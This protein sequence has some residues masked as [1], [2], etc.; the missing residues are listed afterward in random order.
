VPIKFML[1]RFEFAVIVIVPGATPEL[2]IE[3]T[4]WQLNEGLLKLNEPDGVV[5]IVT[6]KENA[7]ATN[8]VVVPGPP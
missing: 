7:I 8:A 3:A 2:L 6:G 1:T 4:P 5:R